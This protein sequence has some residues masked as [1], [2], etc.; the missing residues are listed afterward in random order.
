MRDPGIAV[1]LSGDGGG[2]E[3]EGGFFGVLKDMLKLGWRVEVFSWRHCILHE[4][5]R[6]ARNNGISIDLESYYFAITF[7]EPNMTRSGRPLRG[8]RKSNEL[9]LVTRNTQHPTR[10]SPPPSPPHP[11]WTV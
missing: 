2:Q 3:E 9:N 10:H 7:L 11:G 1:L 6:F 5:K 4:M 8:E